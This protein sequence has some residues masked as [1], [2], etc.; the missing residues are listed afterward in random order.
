[1]NQVRTSELKRLI[2]SEKIEV[3]SFDVFDTLLFRKTDRPETIFDLIGQHFGIHGFR[4][5]RMDEQNTASRRVFASHGYPH[6]DMNEI[7][8]VL[9]E[10]REIPVN[11]NEVKE[12]EIGL[13]KDALVANTEMLEIFRYAKSLNKRVVATSDMYLLA[14]T[15]REILEENGFVGFDHIYCS[16]DEHKAKFNRELFKHVAQHEKV[17]YSHMLHIGDSASADVEIPQSFG[18]NTFLYERSVCFDGVD[19]A[20][21]SD[22]DRGLY[23]ILYDEEKGFW[24][25]FG[26]EAGGPLYMG[27]FRW[28]RDKVKDSGKKLY[29]LSRDGYTLYSLFK[30]AGYDAEYLYTSR[31]ALLLA[32]TVEMNDRDIAEMPPYTYGQTVSEILDYLCISPD[33]IQ[34]LKET[35]F[36]SFHDVI[37]TDEDIRNFKKLYKLDKDVFL[38]R[39]GVERRNAVKYLEKTG[40]LSDDSIVFDC[41][42]SGSSQHLIDRFKRAVKCEFSNYFY[43]FG[44]R[45]TEKSRKQLHGKHYE[46]YAFD[47]CRN[48]SLQARV[49]ESIVIYELLF[50]APHGSVFYYDENGAVLESGDDDLFKGDILRGIEDYLACGLDF[51]DRYN[52]EYSPDSAMGHINRII[53]LPS[54]EEAAKLGDVSNVDGFSRQQGEDKRIAYVTEKQYKNNPRV[55]IFWMRGFFKRSD[56]PESL[57]RQIAADRGYPYPEPPEPEYHLED[58]QSIRNYQRWL[59]NN[60]GAAEYK[61]LEYVPM[62]SVV[63]PVYNTKTEQ[64]TEAIDSVLAQ[65]Y[66]NFELILVD[67]HSSWDNVVPVLR[68]Y[69]SDERVRVIYRSENGH[70]SKATNDGISIAR[71]EFIAFMDC[72]DTIEPDALYQMA[73]E[74]NR[75]PELDFIYSDEDKI[76]EDGRIRHMPFFKPDWSPDLF[77]TM[78]Y[79]NHL[80]VYRASIVKEIGGLRSAYNGS[81]DYDMTLRFMEHSTNSRVGHV[82]RVLYHWRE[83]RESVAFAMGAKNYAVEAGRN[84]KT[85]ALSRRGVSGYLEYIP[86]AMQYRTVYNVTG[87]P[88]VSIIIPSKDNPR[89]LKQCIDSIND[90]TTYRNYEIIVIDNGSN[91]KNHAEIEGYLNKRNIRYLYDR[92]EFNFSLMCNKGAMAASG[93]YLLFLNDDVEII[94]HDWLSRMLGAA[95]QPHVGAVG[96]KLLYPETTLIQHAGVANIYEGPSHNFLRLD[97]SCGY[98]F[99]LNR[100]DYNCIAVTGACLMIG[101]GLFN[102]IGGFDEQLPVAY[103]DI[104]LCFKV[105]EKGYY[106][107]M[108]NDVIAYHHESLSRGD[109]AVSAKKFLRLSR[110]RIK[111][112]QKHSGLLRRDPFLNR[113]LHTYHCTLDTE[114]S[115]GAVEPISAIAP[116]GDIQFSVDR[117]FVDDR[118]HIS[119]WAMCLSRNDNDRL[120][121]YVVMKD[122]YDNYYRVPVARLRRTDVYN[123]FGG[124]EDLI[125]CGIETE[126]DPEI[127]CA[128]DIPYAFGVQLES[129]DGYTAFKWSDARPIVNLSIQHLPEYSAVEKTRVSDQTS[130]C[131]AFY[132]LDEK[133]CDSG[134]LMIKGW[135]FLDVPDHYNYKKYIVLRGAPDSGYQ[136][137]VMPESRL[138]IAMHFMDKH[139]LDRAGF[140]CFVLMDMLRGNTSYEILI[141]FVDKFDPDRIIDIPTGQH[142]EV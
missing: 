86:D 84:A 49:N 55:E 106:N 18:I 128:A 41:G 9:S 8:E 35:G 54:E 125:S 53:M 108:R 100:A 7:Y 142:I 123:A 22:I 45:N 75:D 14:D 117:V 80:A 46:A 135:A 69:E 48:Y 59:F 26:I 77:M 37:R 141:R 16:A 111:L 132:A 89:V 83:R 19:K 24:Y 91:E 105:H 13:E 116:A 96:A 1:M 93:E 67:D 78:M 127:I 107:V 51:A 36:V 20:A 58:E 133:T 64:L 66:P 109:D 85:D 47:F 63:I 82:S 131:G 76:T 140:V 95:Q 124:R 130:G 31:R 4:K 68:S 34:H 103:N 136:V 129:D 10:H 122:P 17:Q 70:I 88:L 29:F 134:S 52:V 137:E 101:S 43:Y 33:K 113:N 112:Y 139:Y 40:F 114:R 118:V 39:C 32:G 11:W 23:K 50:S 74:L 5:L 71:G 79:T 25:N 6:A 2:A 56:I 28:L 57:K 115:Y 61:Q 30:K 38:E 15:L 97:D 119:G 98:Y 73:A 138:D 65:N 81:Q 27:L 99:S 102:S 62:F 92:Y 126:L 3:V 87:D 12:F 44:I 42:W 60:S 94:Q 21:G 72:D 104:D 121:C 90:F 120:R 110:D